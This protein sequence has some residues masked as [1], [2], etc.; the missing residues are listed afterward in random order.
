MS[1]QFRPVSWLSWALLPLL[2]TSSCGPL[3]KEGESGYQLTIQLQTRSSE[4][5]GRSNS[6]NL[7][8]SEFAVLVPAG[9]TF[10]ETGAGASYPP[11]QVSLSNNSVSFTNVSAGSYDLF[12]YRYDTD[13]SSFP[14]TATAID[15]GISQSSLSIPPSTST[16]T[17][18]IQLQKEV[19]IIDSAIQGLNYTAGGRSGTTD[20]D[21]LLYYFPKDTSVTLSLGDIL[22]GTGTGAEISDEAP[23]TPYDLFGVE[24]GQLAD[25]VTNF[26]RLLLTLDNDSQ[27]ENGIQLNSDLSS[28]LGTID[29]ISDFNVDNLTAAH[30]VSLSVSKE[31]ALQHLHESMRRK[32]LGLDNYSQYPEPG[33]DYVA[34]D[35]VVAIAFAEPLRKR[36]VDNLSLQVQY[37]ENGITD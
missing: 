3:P 37:Q 14:A 29:N 30:G 28:N 24:E 16:V 36:S 6:Y 31:E 26:A 27:P 5:L 32:N 34:L 23:I 10:N 18:T 21:G 17:V 7:R 15:Y 13:L 9:T 22:L 1:Y 35:S 2:I 25:N 12:L 8:K 19:A 33:Q 20:A 11:S 4:R